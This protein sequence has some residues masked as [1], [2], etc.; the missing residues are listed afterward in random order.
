MFTNHVF[1]SSYPNKDGGI[2]HIALRTQ[3]QLLSV[4]YS[5]M[6]FLFICF[7]SFDFCCFKLISRTLFIS[8]KTSS[9]C[10]LSSSLTRFIH[11]ASL[12]WSAVMSRP[13]ADTCTTWGD[14]GGK[15]S[16]SK[17]AFKKK[18]SDLCG[19]PLQIF[20]SVSCSCP[21]DCAL[22]CVLHQ[23]EGGAPTW[24]ALSR[25]LG[26]GDQRW[27]LFLKRLPALPTWAI[28]MI[29]ANLYLTLIVNDILKIGLKVQE[30]DNVLK[31]NKLRPWSSDN[32]IMTTGRSK[33]EIGTYSHTKTK[34]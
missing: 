11:A 23:S 5:S 14:K 2:L 26:L 28:R 3:L 10:G 15:A 19:V 17:V 22:R 30:R 25:F 24:L 34:T 12:G 8:E 6:P 1:Q 21:L 16:M 13:D 4:V 33:S 31:I 9:K 7:H 29:R 20:F 18:K 27:R 32:K